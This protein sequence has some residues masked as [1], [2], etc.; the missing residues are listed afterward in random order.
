MKFSYVMLPD[1]PLSESLASIKKADE[2]GF[3]AV[4]VDDIYTDACERDEVLA[5]IGPSADDLAAA[6]GVAAEGEELA[7]GLAGGLDEEPV[8]RA[9]EEEDAEVAVDDGGGGGVSGE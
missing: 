1:Y 3:Y 8:G 2:L 7:G 5:K 4:V 6:D 9:V